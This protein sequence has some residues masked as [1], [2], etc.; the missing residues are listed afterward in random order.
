MVA[1]ITPLVLA[2][3]LLVASTAVAQQPVRP[4]TTVATPRGVAIALGRNDDR[5]VLGVATSSG[6]MRD[7]LGLLIS[8]VTPDSPAE[9]AGLEEG[10]RITAI[11]GVNLRLSAADAG[12]PDMAG[13]LGRR[14]QRELDKVKAGDAVT[15]RV[16]A[17][18]QNRDVSITPVRADELRSSR[19]LMRTR[20]DD[21]TTLGA[22]VGGFSSPRDT[23]G[24]FVVA[25]AEDGPLAQ[26]GIFEGSRIA[27]INGVDLRVPVADVGD[28]FMTNARVRRLTREIEKLQPG[29]NA[30]LRI[31]ANGQYRDVT[32]K[33]VKRSD[34]KHDG[35]ISIFHSGGGTGVFMPSAVE[36]PNIFRF[37]MNHDFDG[38]G[39]EVR[40]RVEEAL[41][42]NEIQLRSLQDRIREEVREGEVLRGLREERFRGFP[43]NERGHD[44]LG[45]VEHDRLL[46]EEARG[47]SA[48]SRS[49]L[50]TSA[51]SARVFN[52]AQGTAVAPLLRTTAAL[53]PSSTLG[54]PGQGPQVNQKGQ[55]K[56]SGTTVSR[57]SA[58]SPEGAV[59]LVS[60]IRMSP[61]N[62]QL[63]SYLGEGSERGLL[64]LEIS[65]KWE[66][67]I[68]GDVLL[69]IDGRAVRKNGMSYVSLDES[70][71]QCVRILRGGQ[72]VKATL[73]MR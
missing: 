47:F 72:T 4:R 24:V 62:S 43:P 58:D 19:T 50:M 45:S 64:I 30:A 15:L 34:L 32:V 66:G 11:N 16:Y 21:R 6:G 8:S 35:A 54:P 27:S 3:A 7:T 31:H 56:S 48:P 67:L 5:L 57:S 68:A 63:A 59:F 55:G 52:V 10:N 36:M 25:V 20:A 1:Q 53:S 51:S 23:I 13:V 70:K 39:S 46:L 18:G 12:E 28:D 60:G 49:A 65:D 44:D 38:V 2:T 71:D 61:I 73:R 42:G 37:D 41:R 9:K 17:N 26:A 14:L 40:E 29:E 69:S 33:V 22:S